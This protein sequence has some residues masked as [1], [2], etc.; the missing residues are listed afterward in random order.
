MNLLP[1][2]LSS[3]RIDR[4]SGLTGSLIARVAGL[5]LIATPAFARTPQAPGSA[6]STGEAPPAAGGVVP[7]F[8]P[9]YGGAQG[10]VTL[11]ARD[12]AQE[13]LS[14]KGWGEG[15]NPNG[16]WVVIGKSS[17]PCGANSKD[18]DQCRRQAYEEAMFQAKRAMVKRLAD[19]VRTEIERRY[20]EGDV[21][22]R[23]SQQ[24]QVTIA[25]EP[26][27]MDK[28]V[29]LADNVI[30]KEL[31]DRG[32]QVGPSADNKAWTDEERKKS[33][34]AARKEAQ[35]LLSKKE[36]RSAVESVASCEISGIQA[37]RTFEYVPAGKNGSIA[38]IAIYSEKSDELQRALLGLGPVPS[39]APKE[40]IAAWA[41]SEGPQSLLYTFG[42]QPRTNEKGEVVLVSFGQSTPI[43][44]SEDSLDAAEEK[45][46]LAA[47]GAARSFL[48]ELVMSQQMQ[49]EASTLKQ[50]ADNAAAFESQSAFTS[51]IKA[52]AETLS[53]PGGNVVYNWKMKHPLSNKVTCGVVKVYSVS[54]ALMAN[55]LREK[56]NA[57]A[58]SRGGRG[59][60][61]KQPP[62]TPP[63]SGTKTR[64]RTGSGNG[65][66]A[67]G[68][69][70]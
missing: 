34:E 36:F 47:S 22:K 59:I 65:S 49:V 17:L 20:A 3:L 30:S 54:D 1:S 21:L 37:Y 64:Q 15:V 12:Q 63:A 61:D 7:E 55:K 38:V 19:R 58:A 48:G 66:G 14:S 69:A 33:E 9:G 26:S 25:A 18:F 51:A 29:A 42:V 2:S 45:A 50:F 6:P 35:Q 4:K 31:A 5:A 70:P 13:F 24:R 11:D 41:R 32:V 43:T 52:T 53:M 46:D 27:L 16:M 28:V 23:M 44:D 8:Q 62:S 67:E 10:S 57:L 60:S 68:E 56:F 40:P 39:G